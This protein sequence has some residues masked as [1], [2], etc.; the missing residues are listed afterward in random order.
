[1]VNAAGKPVGRIELK[2]LVRAMAAPTTAT[3]DDVK[4]QT[5]GE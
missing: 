3:A 1:V 4:T 5:G 2:E